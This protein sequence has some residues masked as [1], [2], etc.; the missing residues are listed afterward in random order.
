M[1]N[2]EVTFLRN[3]LEN[4]AIDQI[5]D[6][7]KLKLDISDLRVEDVSLLLNVVENLQR[8]FHVSNVSVGLG[9]E[10]DA[11]GE[12]NVKLM[13]LCLSD[14]V[15]SDDEGIVVE[16]TADENLDDQIELLQILVFDE[17]LLLA[18]PEGLLA[19]LEG[20]HELAI[21]DEESVEKE[22]DSDDVDGQAGMGPE[23][24]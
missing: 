18:E 24:E 17:A 3:K 12:L 21:V 15:L 19:C 20:V 4:L 8:G 5:L 1:I 16:A 23:P 13:G 7:A 2:K 10:E 11:G 9:F 22:V 6:S 14:G